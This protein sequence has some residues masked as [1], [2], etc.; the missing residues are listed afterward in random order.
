LIKLIDTGNFETV[1]CQY[2][3][4]DRSNE[5]AIAHAKRKGLGV[6]I[7]GPVGGGKLGEP[8][9]TIKKLLPK[10]TVSCAE[11]ALRFVLANPNVDCAL[12]GMSTI[13]MV[14]ENVRVASNDTPLTKEELEMIRAS[15]EETNE[16]RICI[17]PAAIIV[18]RVLSV[19]IF[20]LIFS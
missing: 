14:E 18:C 11:I 5:K 16:W 3:L 8:S 12:S 20:R 15:M 2:N 1:L 4:L 19:S 10:K 13:E 7:M 6:I 17:A 9:E